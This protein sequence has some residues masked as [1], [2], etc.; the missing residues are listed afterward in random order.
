MWMIQNGQLS[1]YNVDAIN[2]TCNEN[3]ES[4]WEELLVTV[5]T[6]L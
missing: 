4:D 6:N 5:A 2:D 1:D 3:G